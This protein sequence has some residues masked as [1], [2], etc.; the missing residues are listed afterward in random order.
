MIARE[1]GAFRGD[2]RVLALIV[3]AALALTGRAWLAEHPEHDPGAPLNLNDPRG[4]A[5]ATKL[6]ALRS[7]VPECRA[8][9]ERSGVA[10][11][12]LDP[13]GEGECRR[14]DRLTLAEA[15]LSPASPQLTCPVAAGLQMWI[16]KDV[17]RL[18]EETLDTRVA[19]IDQLGTY[20]CRR[21]YGAATGGWS[22]HATGNAIDIAGFVMEDG[23]H[24]S[25]LRDW[26]GDTPESEF[27]QSVRDAA[28]QSFG[29][30]LSPDYNAA[31]ADHLHLDQGRALV[32]GA[33][34]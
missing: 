2:R 8:V 7:D 20:S 31:H 27:L 26:A 28:C 15:P 1:I 19:R 11:T 12:P 25:I 21:M 18:A 17:Q 24:V 30:V 14:E 23:R 4:W 32:M 10:F 3:V 13:V 16:D 9:L 6:A 5:T 34:R 29:T 33:C 22:E